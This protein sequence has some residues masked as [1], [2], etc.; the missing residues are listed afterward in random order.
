MEL[1]QRISSM[2]LSIRKK[3]NIR[4]RQPLQ[5]VKIPVVHAEMAEKIRKVQDLILSE[6]NVK[7][8]V[9][10]DESESKFV[11]NLKLNFKTLGKKCGKAMKEVQ[12]FAEQNGQ[13]MIEDIEKKALTIVPTSIGDMELVMEDVEIIPVDIPGWKVVNQG[14]LTVA[15]DVTITETLRDEGIAREVVN[16]IQNI[17]KESQLSVTDRIQV[18]LTANSIWNDA[19]EKNSQYIRNQVL[20]DVITFVNDLQEG[21][22]VEWDENLTL[23]I[24]IQKS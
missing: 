16:R 21:V 9:F 18:S 20:A 19:I 13:Q 23:N 2:V 7:E 4:V 5:S 11:K 15:L 22:T 3:E 14:N 12:L 8:L 6:V 1:A 10:V 17:R 24:H